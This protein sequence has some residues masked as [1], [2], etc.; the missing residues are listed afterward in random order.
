MIEEIVDIS[1][2][3]GAM[4]TFICRPERDVPAPAI[5]LLTVILPEPVLVAIVSTLIVDIVL[6]YHPTMKV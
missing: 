4:E 5:L 2:A 6:P 1:T 3:D